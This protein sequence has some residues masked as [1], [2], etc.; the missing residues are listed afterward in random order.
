MLPGFAPPARLLWEFR[1]SLDDP[2]YITNT[3]D[4]IISMLKNAGFGAVSVGGLAGGWTIVDAER[5]S[6]T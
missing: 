1:D 4:D 6:S 5:P 2:G 3:T